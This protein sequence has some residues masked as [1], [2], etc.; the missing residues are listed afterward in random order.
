MVLQSIDILI[1]ITDISMRSIET[2]DSIRNRAAKFTHYKDLGIIINRVR[3]KIDPILNKLNEK[4]LPIL[5]QIP[6]DDKIINFEL[7]GKPLIDL[8]EDSISYLAIKEIL[9]K[10][11]K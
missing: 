2:A 1:I 6:E 7:E 8:Q 11:L 9:T 3:G 5:G 4:K 10:I